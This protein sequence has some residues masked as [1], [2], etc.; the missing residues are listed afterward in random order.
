VTDPELELRK[1]WVTDF[2]TL[3]RDVNLHEICKFVNYLP[4]RFCHSG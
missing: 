4:V 1:R 3:D 2:R